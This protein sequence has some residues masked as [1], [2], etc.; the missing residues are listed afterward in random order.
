MFRLYHV[1]N[2]IAVFKMLNISYV[3]STYYFPA[4]LACKLV[5]YYV[6]NVFYLLI[7]VHDVSLSIAPQILDRL[8]CILVGTK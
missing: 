6:S 1:I 2:M 4:K 3:K 8:A 7:Y 5:K